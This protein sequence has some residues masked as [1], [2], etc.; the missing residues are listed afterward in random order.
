MPFNNLLRLPSP[1]RRNPRRV[2][3]EDIRLALL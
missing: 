1:V 2:L 3:L